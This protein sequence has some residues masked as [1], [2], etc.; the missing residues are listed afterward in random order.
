MKSAKRLRKIVKELSRDPWLKQAVAKARPVSRGK[1]GSQIESLANAY[2]ALSTIASGLSKKK[3]A[4]ALQERMDIVYFLV[5]MSLLLKEN[6]L[7]RPEVRQFL[8]RSASGIYQTT[9]QS[10]GMAT[11][12]RKRLTRGRSG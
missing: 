2:A 9:R 11:A 7:D 4:R 6:V 3:K 10:L 8:N 5:Q 1:R 12:K